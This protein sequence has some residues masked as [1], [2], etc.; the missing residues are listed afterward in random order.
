M[1]LHFLGTTGYHP[2]ESRQTACLMLPE[3][4]WIL[5]A[6]TGIFRARDLIQTSTLKIFLTHTHLDHSIGIT[7]LFDILW[8]K[9]VEQVQVYALPEKIQSLK[10]HLFHRDLFPLMPEIEFVPLDDPAL[11][12][13]GIR[14][15][16]IPLEHP[17]GSLGFL[18]E[19][20]GNSL[21]YITDTTARPDADYVSRIHD[22]DLLIH[23]CYFPDGWEDR[24]TLT[25]HS[26]LTPVCEV[27]RDCNAGRLFLVHI[28]PMDERASQLDLEAARDFFSDITIAEDKMV[29]DW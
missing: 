25:G 6:G 1:K 24:A 16:T 19:K 2:N 4:G 22:V 20:E 18:L 9:N 15:S 11:E 5:D 10:T 21:A 17:G 28:N 12:L 29:I 7:F 26:C 8:E 23:E 13:D 27:A 14:L 3:I